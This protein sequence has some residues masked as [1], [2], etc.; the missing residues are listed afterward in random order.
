SGVARPERY[1]SSATHEQKP[2]DKK[3]IGQDA[4]GRLGRL[5]LSNEPGH[6]SGSETAH[7]FAAMAK[8]TST[9]ERSFFA[10]AGP[11]AITS[12]LSWLSSFALL[13]LTVFLPSFA[14][15]ARAA[16]FAAER[17]LCT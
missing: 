14:I 10:R 6:L 16:L 15:R 11:R 12:S 5:S 8:E 13:P 9:C 1:G 3:R 2:L 4:V 17:M 7:F